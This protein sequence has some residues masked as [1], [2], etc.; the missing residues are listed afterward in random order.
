M[1]RASV[2]RFL[3]FS[4]REGMSPYTEIGF[5]RGKPSAVRHAPGVYSGVFR[6]KLKLLC[7]LLNYVICL[8]IVMS[9]VCKLE[10]E[11]EAAR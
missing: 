9:Y 3:S 8:H 10:A 6:I 7:F 2:S 5:R 1:G 4:P 11:H